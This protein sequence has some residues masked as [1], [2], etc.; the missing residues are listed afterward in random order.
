MQLARL[1]P[2]RGPIDEAAREAESHPC[3]A[4]HPGTVQNDDGH[5]RG[6][7]P[8]AADAEVDLL[9][10]PG[11]VEDERRANDDD[12][13]LHRDVDGRDGNVH[14]GRFAERAAVD[15]GEVTDHHGGRHDVGG[16]SRIAGRT[17]NALIAIVIR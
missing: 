14:A 17:N 5:P 8:E 4:R 16:P 1:G 6:R 12:G 13:R 15:S 10:E 9:D 2:E 3:A 7:G 11:G